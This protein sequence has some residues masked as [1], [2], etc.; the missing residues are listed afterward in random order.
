MMTTDQINPIGAVDFPG[1]SR[2]FSGSSGRFRY[3]RMEWEVDVGMSPRR[4]VGRGKKSQK[5]G[6]TERLWDML[7]MS[8]WKSVNLPGSA[9]IIAKREES[10][11]AGDGGSVEKILTSLGQDMRWSFSFDFETANRIS[12]RKGTY[13]L[14]GSECLN[15]Y[16]ILEGHLLACEL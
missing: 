8:K 14:G 5:G 2:V 11:M 3:A 4:T 15:R 13:R 6:G 10:G 1:R 16:S 9:F 12:S 7:A